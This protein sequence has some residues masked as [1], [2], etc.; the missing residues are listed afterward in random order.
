MSWHL[1]Q[2]NIARSVEPLDSP[3]LAG[4]MEALDPINAIADAAPGFV[5]RLETEAGNATALKPFDGDELMIVNLSVWESL[6]ALGDFV[7]LRRE[8]P[9]DA[10][11]T[12]RRPF[13]APDTAIVPDPELDTCEA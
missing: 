13:P 5:W 4:F 1:A 3:T 7:R 2:L 8:G 6:E 12:F 9:T 11:F 10:A